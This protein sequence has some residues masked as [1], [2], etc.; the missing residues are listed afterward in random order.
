MDRLNEAWRQ[1]ENEF[2]KYAPCLCS[3]MAIENIIQLGLSN[4]PNL[5]FYSSS[6]DFIHCIWKYILRKMVSPD[7]DHVRLLTWEKDV[8]YAESNY[9][10]ELDLAFPS[11]TK[12]IEKIAE[13]VKSIA[14]HRKFVGDRHIFIIRNL[15]HVISYNGGA[16]A[17]RVLLEKYSSNILFICT[18]NS[19]AKLEKPLQSRFMCVR[20][21]CFS[22]EVVNRILFDT[23]LYDHAS[24]PAL[25]IPCTEKRNLSYCMYAAVAEST[26]GM[27]FPFLKD[28]LGTGKKAT[29]EQLR[30][31]TNKLHAY[32]APVSRIATDLIQIMNMNMRTKHDLNP[33]KKC[34]VLSICVNV[35]HML[36][37]NDGNRKALYIE[38]LLNAVNEII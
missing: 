32:D 15:Q 1:F 13:F 35:D 22:E 14:S 28:Y 34:L 9:H 3:H 8:F 16:Q 4:S 30:S 38:Y 5:L 12:S 29:V 24:M 21:P 7:I 27:Y 2:E 25:A 18:S 10:F 26:H 19:I 37:Q 17:F 11:Q 33:N 23:G 6:A 20:I 31:L 36:A